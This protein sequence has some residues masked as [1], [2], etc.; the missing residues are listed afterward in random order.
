[1]A[2]EPELLTSTI[3]KYEIKREKKSYLEKIFACSL[4]FYS[5]LKNTTKQSKAMF[6]AQLS[7][8]P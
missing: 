5:L 8:F 7:I 2:P 1:M 4:P 6:C 3:N